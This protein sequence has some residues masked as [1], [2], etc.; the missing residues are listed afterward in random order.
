MDPVDI[1]REFLHR[2]AGIVLE[3]GQEHFARTRLAPV[4]QLA[5]LSGLSSLASR[6]EL[7]D[8]ALRRSVLEAMVTHETLFFRDRS[9]FT[10]LEDVMLPALHS[11]RSETRRLRI[12]SSA[13]ST[14]QEP[15]SIAMLLDEKA[16]D[17]TG[18]WIEIAATDLSGRA[19]DRARRGRFSQFEVQRG[20]S[21]ARLLRYFARAGDDWQVAEHLRE[22]IQFSEFNLLG[23]LGAFG[24]CDIVFCRNVFLYFDAATIVCV[25][26]RLARIIPPDGFLV[27]GGAETLLGRNDHFA[28]HPRQAGVLVRRVAESGKPTLKLATG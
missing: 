18:W 20:L 5:G 9:L 13:C 1:L 11:A 25:L 24:P 28:Q 4:I 16:R 7:G 6:V 10:F 15:Y 2:Q 21:T 12:W 8:H 23:D 27:I 22:R 19:I 14:G 3:P 26:D 17:F